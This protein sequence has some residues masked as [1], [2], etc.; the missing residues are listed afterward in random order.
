M[1][2]DEIEF[3]TSINRY[4]DSFKNILRASWRQSKEE[5][6]QWKSER[7]ANPNVPHPV[8]KHLGIKIA[9]LRT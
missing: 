7:S 5:C 2:L 1:R 4:T 3:E 9:G 8:E 6:E